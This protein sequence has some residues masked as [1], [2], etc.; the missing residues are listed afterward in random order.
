MGT[1]LPVGR[2]PHSPGT[3]TGTA[4]CERQRRRGRPGRWRPAGSRPASGHSATRVAAPWGDNESASAPCGD[5]ESASATA[6]DHDDATADHHV[7]SASFAPCGDHYAAAPC[8]DHT[9]AAR[10]DA[11]RD[12]YADAAH[13]GRTPRGGLESVALTTAHNHADARRAGI[14][15]VASINAGGTVSGLL[16]SPTAYM[17]SGPTPGPGQGAGES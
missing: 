10:D 3:G 1:G 8:G 13:D 11:A 7:E 9:A 16:E 4:G 17:T 15:S 12:G 6:G 2:R 14:G 5:N